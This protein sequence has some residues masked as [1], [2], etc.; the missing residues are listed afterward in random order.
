MYA[1]RA[2]WMRRMHTGCVPICAHG[3]WR[4]HCTHTCIL[5]VPRGAHIWMCVHTH[6]LRSH[7]ALCVMY[8]LCILRCMYVYSAYVTR[9]MQCEHAIYMYVYTSRCV[10]HAA[11]AVCMYVYS[12]CTTRHVRIYVHTG[13]VAHPA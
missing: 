2:P 13:H 5:R 12:V 4:T 6:I 8:T 10:R 11:H 7:A 3:V 1:L 9:R